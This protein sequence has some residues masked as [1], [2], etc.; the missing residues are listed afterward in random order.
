VKHLLFEAAGFRHGSDAILNQ[1]SEDRCAQ[2]KQ[3]L[4]RPTVCER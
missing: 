2:Q 3:A 4:S 1:E